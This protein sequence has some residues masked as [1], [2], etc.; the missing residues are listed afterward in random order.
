MGIED[1]SL[2]L[3]EH[4]DR[5]LFICDNDPAA[6]QISSLL[7]T[8]S[9]NWVR[10]STIED[11][12]V[13][14]QEQVFDL[15]VICLLNPENDPIINLRDLKAERRLVRY[16]VIA[17]H[18]ALEEIQMSGLIPKDEKLS[19]LPY[20]IDAAQFLVKLTMLLRL[21]KF[22]GEQASFET[23]IAEQNAQLRDLTNRF[24]TEVREAQT[25]QKALLPTTLPIFDSCVIAARYLPLEAVGGDLYDVFNIDSE[26]VGIFL[27]DVTG[28]GLPAAFI[29]AMTKMALAYA[30]KNSPDKMLIEMNDGM[31]A[32]MP[33]GRFVAVAAATYNINTGVLKVARGG[34][35]NPYIWRAKTQ[36][37]EM[38]ISRGM[39]VGMVEGICYQLFET[40]LEPGDKFLMLTDGLTEA[41][42]MNGVMLGAEGVVKWLETEAGTLPIDRCLDY[43]LFLQ[44]RFCGGRILK[45]DITLVGLER[46]K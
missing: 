18:P 16:P 9:Y 40:I 32:L 38:A 10:V 41:T 33:E 27:G 13:T 36:S 26:N 37:V 29:G 15:V 5:I 17:I 35:P 30:K 7:E 6:A 20:P 23:K 3:K 34:Q 25:I 43:L 24:R 42:D 2:D 21:R 12:A 8:R 1:L 4:A 11:G 31:I 22:R 28:H 45:D 39:A 46:T 14:A 44:E 19:L